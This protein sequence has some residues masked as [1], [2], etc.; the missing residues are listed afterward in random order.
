MT[1][2]LETDSTSEGPKGKIHVDVFDANGGLLSTVDSQ[3]VGIGGKHPGLSRID[4]F[5]GYQNIPMPVPA[6]AAS[7]KVRPE[8]TGKVFQL[9]GIDYGQLLKAV[10][11][12]VTTLAGGSGQP[13]AG[14]Q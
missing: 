12:L 11:L 5:S 14:S 4:N 1:I 10:S 7:I 8:C 9:F 13:Q 3:E 6:I 2:Q